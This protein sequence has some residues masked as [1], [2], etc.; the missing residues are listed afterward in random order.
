MIDLRL[1]RWEDVLQGVEVDALICDPPY[2]ARTHD[3]QATG[4]GPSRLDRGRR[5]L[6]GP[7]PFN[8]WTPP[9]VHGFVTAWNLRVR[10]WIAC[11]TDSE[12]MPHWRE[13][14]DRVGRCSFA[15][16]PCVIRGMTCR[17]A[18]D[19]PS[20]WAVYLMVARPRSQPWSKWGTLPGAYASGR[21]PG[22]KR[23]GWIGGGKPLSLMR[24]IIRDYSRP[25]DLVCDPCAGHSTT[26]IA[27]R[28]EGR[29]AIGSEVD[30][31]AYNASV[32]RIDTMGRT[33]GW[34][35]EDI[36]SAPSGPVQVRMW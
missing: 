30:E 8:A 7:V 28:C 25:G 24:Q 22:V 14:F 33:Y 4:E 9:D 19:G 6:R 18:G 3:G 35:A 20:S 26:L 2:S 36:D 11:L 23:E 17:L 31:G 21:G 10:G 16:V 32:E 12:L 5:I 1:G 15:P 29:R 34:S 27:A 13:A